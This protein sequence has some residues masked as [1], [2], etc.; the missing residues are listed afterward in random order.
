MTVEITDVDLMPS[1]LTQPPTGTR[2][3]HPRSCPQYFRQPTTGAGQSN[4]RTPQPQPA[5]SCRPHHTTM[6]VGPTWRHPTP[7]S[8]SKPGAGAHHADSPTRQPNVTRDRPIA[9]APHGQ[10]THIPRPPKHTR[11]RCGQINRRTPGDTTSTPHATWNEHL[12]TSTHALPIHHT[13]TGMAHTTGQPRRRPDGPAHPD[14]AHS[15]RGDHRRRPGAVRPEQ[16]GTAPPSNPVEVDAT[17]ACDVKLGG[18]AKKVTSRSH[19]GPAR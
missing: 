11:N 18:E 17:F 14:R 2:T 7:A 12:A 5:H 8:P 10:R 15:D 6:G 13:T 16:D 19:Q 4:R 3:A 9:A 1:Q